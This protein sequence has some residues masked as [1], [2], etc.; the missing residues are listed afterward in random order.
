MKIKIFITLLLTFIYSD[1]QFTDSTK[2]S[3]G[4]DPSFR[5]EGDISI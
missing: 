2:N 4:I 3:D 5:L 1:T